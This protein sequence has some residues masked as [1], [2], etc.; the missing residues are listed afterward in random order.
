MAIKSRRQ[1]E[2]AQRHNLIVSTARQLAEQEGWQTVTTRKLADSIEYSQPV[3]YSHFKNKDEIIRAV[4]IQGFT[5]LAELQ[6]RTRESADTPE[7][8]IHL[9]FHAYGRFAAENPRL[10][11]AMFVHPTNLLFA[12]EDTPEELH[13]AFQEFHSAIAAVAHGR[14]A[15]VLTEITWASLHGLATLSATHRLR[16]EQSEARLSMLI[17]GLLHLK[18]GKASTDHP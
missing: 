16:P 17:E 14:D 7:E 8:A 3:L 4:A 2:I 13:G 12:A 5:E 11:E 10:Y 6:R 1:R 9:L 18:E 15:E